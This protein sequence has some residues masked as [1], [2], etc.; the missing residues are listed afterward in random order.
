[1][2]QRRPSSATILDRMAR[3][4]LVKVLGR[5]N[6]V[7]ITIRESGS[8]QTYE[9]G[10]PQENHFQVEVHHPLFYRRVLLGGSLGAAESY[11]EGHWTCDDLTGLIRAM[12]QNLNVLHQLDSRLTR[13]LGVLSNLAHWLRKNT[14]AGSRRNIAEHYDLGNDFFKLFLD[15]TMLYSSGIFNRPESTLY[16]SSLAKMERICRRLQ[17]QPTDH[18]LEIGTGWGGFALYAAK[19][20]GCRITTTTI[21]QEQYDLACQRIQEAG[22]SD[23]V[24]VIQQDYRELTGTY[25]KLVSI[26]MIEAVGHEYLNQFFSTC[27][28]LLKPDGLMLVQAIVMNEQRYAEYLKSTDF[29]QK[30]VFPGGCLPSVLT[31]G[32]SVARSTDLRILHLDDFAAHY[33]QTLRCWRSGFWEA[34]NQVREL[35]FTERFI[36]LWHYYLC[37]CEAAFDE[38]F[39]GLV[40]LVLAKP[41]YRAD[42]IGFQ[43]QTSTITG[44]TQTSRSSP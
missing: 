33:A 13:W 34:I 40:Q 32:N 1:M 8:N 24:H 17:L 43:P 36:R 4:A 11:L 18:L 27:A 16:E 12:I 41:A 29:I 21:S 30:H 2:N 9:L 10:A 39:I 44:S 22:L 42:A 20:Y 37:Y 31:M 35:G 19:N 38:R 23:R 6:N 25:D 15:E 7:H 3:S 5:L 14:I 26:E 28:R